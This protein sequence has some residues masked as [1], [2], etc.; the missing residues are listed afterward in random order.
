MTTTRPSQT[1][2]LTFNF[3]IEQMLM[4]SAKKISAM[5]A[6]LA[7]LYEIERHAGEIQNAHEAILEILRP[8]GTKAPSVGEVVDGVRTIVECYEENLRR[9]ET[10]RNELAR[11]KSERSLS[12]G[13]EPCDWMS[14]AGDKA[15]D[16]AGDQ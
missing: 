6:E 8:Y 5:R 15:G 4:E 14:K 2:D 16:G 3:P 9:L 10:V 1:P 12:S 11:V 13:R 7:R